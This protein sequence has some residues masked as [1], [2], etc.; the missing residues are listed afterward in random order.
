MPLLMPSQI[1]ATNPPNYFTV[2]WYTVV[3]LNVSPGRN[4]VDGN[5][6]WFGESGKC[7]VSRHRPACFP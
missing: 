7:C 1:R 3:L 4:T 2:K 5:D 6:G